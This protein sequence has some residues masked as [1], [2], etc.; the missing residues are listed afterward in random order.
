MK[1]YT[2]KQLIKAFAAKNDF[3]L[4]YKITKE[5]AK[6]EIDDLLSFIPENTAKKESFLEKSLSCCFVETEKLEN[7]PVSFEEVKVPY[8][9]P[10]A[11]ETRKESL[12]NYEPSQQAL[13]IFALINTA[14][15][16]GNFSTVYKTRQQ[17]IPKSDIGFLNVK[18]FKTQ[19]IHTNEFKIIW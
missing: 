2:R 1:K 14:K 8:S 17:G 4:A 3:P 10:T 7:I 15:A 12:K 9:F 6:A 13:N 5:Q 16:N 19:L 18:G 11:E